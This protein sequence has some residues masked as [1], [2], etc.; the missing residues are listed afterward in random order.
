VSLAASAAAAAGVAPLLRLTQAPVSTWRPVATPTLVV[1]N[2]PW[3]LRL[4]GAAGDDSS[5]SG[6]GADSRSGSRDRDWG[7]DR[8]G[9]GGQVAELEGVW[10]DLGDWLKRECPGGLGWVYSFI[11]CFSHVQT[12]NLQS[13]CG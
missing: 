13:A 7:R 6:R 5:S 1:T 3:G 8:E 12:P 11:Q 10:R 4:M 2:P 9:R